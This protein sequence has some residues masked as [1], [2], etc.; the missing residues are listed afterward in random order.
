MKRFVLLSAAALLAWQ[1]I[2]FAEGSAAPGD[3]TDGPAVLPFTFF[4]THYELLGDQSNPT[5]V[6]YSNDGAPFADTPNGRRRIAISGAGAWDPAA[7][8]ATGGGTY[9]ITNREGRVVS[10]GTWTALRFKSFLQ[11]PGWWAID[12]FVEEGWQGPPG[13]VSFSGF[14]ELR[15]ELDDGRR[16]LLTAW[17][18]MPTTPH[19][20][21]HISDGVSLT[22]EEL[23]FT[24]TTATEMSFEGMMFYGPEGP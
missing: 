19:H 14:L 12:G 16:G 4:T 13:S 6:R 5:G 23:N 22:G 18:I 21:G 20:G 11:L 10:D 9:E 15:I 3:R 1:A 8:A 2:A 17:C 7:E 24:D